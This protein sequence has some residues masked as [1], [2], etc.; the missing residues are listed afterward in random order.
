MTDSTWIR[1]IHDAETAKVQWINSHIAQ[2]NFADFL[3][4]PSSGTE[5][6]A[7]HF[8][9]TF[10]SS[11]IVC[12]VEWADTAS[13]VC[14]HVADSSTNSGIKAAIVLCADEFRKFNSGHAL[15]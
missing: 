2:G 9:D 15:V 3:D 10:S 5:S 1:A 8:I 12:V 11:S 14:I 13:D 4:T 7:G 6:R